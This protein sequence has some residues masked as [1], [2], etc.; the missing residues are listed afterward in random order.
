MT[1]R[2]Y[3]AFPEMKRSTLPLSQPHVVWMEYGVRAMHYVDAVSPL[4]AIADRARV[5]GRLSRAFHILATITGTHAVTGQTVTR[6]ALDPQLHSRRDL[7]AHGAMAGRVQ[8]VRVSGRQHNA[9][10]ALYVPPHPVPSYSPMLSDGRVRK[11]CRRLM[12][13]ARRATVVPEFHGVPHRHEQGIM[14]RV[15]LDLVHTTKHQHLVLE[16]ERLGRPILHAASLP[17]RTNSAAEAIRDML[18][19]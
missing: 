13:R 1:C 16:Q 19:S 7:H 9:G 4:R 17:P 14:L 12:R 8:C 18:S 6:C 15:D 11:R 10:H 2:D 3:T 5:D